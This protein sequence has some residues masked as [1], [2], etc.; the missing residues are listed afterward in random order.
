MP[1]N[2][3]KMSPFFS[4]ILKN[5]VFWTTGCVHW[6]SVKLKTQRKQIV[7]FIKVDVLWALPLL[8]MDY[9]LEKV[10]AWLIEVLLVQWLVCPV[11]HRGGGS[12]CKLLRDDRLQLWRKRKTKN[13]LEFT[14]ESPWR[15][16]RSIWSFHIISLL[17]ACEK[18]THSYAESVCV[19][20]H[21]R[22]TLSCKSWNIWGVIST[23]YLGH[24]FYWRPGIK[25][26]STGE[27]GSV[28]GNNWGNIACLEERAT[29]LREGPESHFIFLPITFFLLRLLF[30][31]FFFFF[32]FFLIK[33]MLSW[34][35]ETGG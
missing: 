19:S 20:A 13:G 10:A 12:K 24:P 32:S 1:V 27:E 28:S 15:A 4:W 31:F 35:F 21:M 30:F 5:S 8:E 7:C 26:S 11:S 16:V 22:R 18:H 29:L 23:L 25:T 9:I 6:G 2:Y 3:N 14:A 17:I 34:C 33:A